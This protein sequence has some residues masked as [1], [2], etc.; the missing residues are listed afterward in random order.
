M[1]WP[2][3]SFWASLA[4][5]TSSLRERRQN[6][7]RIGGDF[8]GS[9]PSIEQREYEKEKRGGQ[10][11]ERRS[12]LACVSRLLGFSIHDPGV[13]DDRV[14]FVSNLAVSDRSRLFSWCW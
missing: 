1:V 7:Q 6:S 3:R 9:S 4:E 12:S 5:T 10:S 13:Y 14:V 8:I 11:F 2:S